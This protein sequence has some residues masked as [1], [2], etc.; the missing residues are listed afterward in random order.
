VPR[1]PVTDGPNLA[2][3]LPEI[4]SRVPA[5]LTEQLFETTVM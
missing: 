4:A 2:G 5:S 1:S 3:Y